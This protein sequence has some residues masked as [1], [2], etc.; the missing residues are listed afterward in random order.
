M[1]TRN[2]PN[3]HFPGFLIIFSLLR[4]VLNQIVH[5]VIAVDGVFVCDIVVD[6]V[7]VYLDQ[8]QNQSLY[9][10]YHLVDHQ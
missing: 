7:Q 3:V 9:Y 1:M 2:E 5:S 4:N 8:R 6:L 10:P